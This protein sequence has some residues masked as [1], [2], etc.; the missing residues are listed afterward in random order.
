MERLRW[1]QVWVCSRSQHTELS[2]CC[3]LGYKPRAVLQLGT[4]GIEKCCGRW[5]TNF[6]CSCWPFSFPASGTVGCSQQGSAVGAGVVWAVFYP[7]RF[8]LVCLCWEGLICSCLFPRIFLW[9]NLLNYL[10]AAYLMHSRSAPYFV[11]LN[12]LANSW[13]FSGLLVFYIFILLLGSSAERHQR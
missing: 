8:L 12:I 4:P 1:P 2:S 11:L 6:S 10:N 3:C 9:L 13:Y 7:S 5:C